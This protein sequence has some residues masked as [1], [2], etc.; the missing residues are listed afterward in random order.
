M[1]WISLFSLAGFQVMVIGRITEPTRTV[2][3]VFSE[4]RVI[5]PEQVSLIAPI[6]EMATSRQ[7][8]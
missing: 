4:W 8:G 6:N 5:R 1:S 2:G 7:L 3:Q